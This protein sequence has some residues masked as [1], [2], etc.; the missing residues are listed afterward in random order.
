MELAL[1]LAGLLLLAGCPPAANDNAAEDAN[2]QALA[3]NTYMAAPN[4]IY[5]SSSTFDLTWNVVYESKEKPFDPAIN[6]TNRQLALNRCQNCHECGF[7]FA[8]DMDNF[9]TTNWNPRYK[10]D[11]W[12]PV[13]KRMVDKPGSF[14]NE[15]I[16]ERIYNYLNEESLGLYDESKDPRGRNTISGQKADENQKRVDEMV[17]VN[18]R[19]G[20]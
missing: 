20:R 15:Q 5:D 6:V 10:A 9:G 11:E 14:M 16:A 3:S 17:E 12:A 13:V 19:P 2:D 4:K 1:W 18:A 8:F 7:K